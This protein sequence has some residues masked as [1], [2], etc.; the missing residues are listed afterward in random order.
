MSKFEKAMK[1]LFVAGTL[2]AAGSSFA[3]TQGDLGATS[4]GTIE[5]MVEI[6]DQI[7]ISGLID[8][9]GGYVPGEDFT[10][11]SPACV[12][13]NGTTGEFDVTISSQNGTGTD[14]RLNDAGTFVTYDVTF[15]DGTSGA[16]DMNHAELDNTSFDNA[17]NENPTCGGDAQST[18]AITVPDANLGA[19]GAGTYADTLTI[20]V[21]PR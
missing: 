11:S 2:V 13:R 3:A 19:V 12:F 18:I 9:T 20:L 1:G 15:D 10:G 6:V 16:I 4:Q 7:Q 17:S 21:A 14:F 5:V 8:I